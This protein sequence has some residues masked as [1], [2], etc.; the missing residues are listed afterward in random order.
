MNVVL[1]R[2]WDDSGVQH[3]LDVKENQSFPTSFNLADITELKN[4]KGSFNKSIDLPATEANVSYFGQYWNVNEVDTFDTKTKKRAILEYDTVKVLDG[5][6]QLVEVRVEN[7]FAAE[8]NV[9]IFSDEGGLFKATEN[10]LLKDLDLSDFDHEVSL[11]NVVSGFTG[12][13]TPGGETIYYGLQ[14]YGTQITTSIW[15]TTPNRLYQFN[16]KP[17]LK[18]KSLFDLIM[19]EAGYTYES[20]FLNGTYFNSLYL[21][22][23]SGSN[24]I[25]VNVNE[26]LF[27]KV[28]LTSDED[29]TEI[30]LSAN[31]VTFDDETSFDFFDSSD[32]MQANEGYASLFPGY[33]APASALGLQ[34]YQFNVS[35]KVTGG[36]DTVGGADPYVIAELYIRQGGSTFLQEQHQWDLDSVPQGDEV[37]LTHSFTP[38]SNLG[39]YWIQVYHNIQSNPFATPPADEQ[40]RIL[41]DEDSFFECS[42][43]PNLQLVDVPTEVDINF[44][45]SLNV[46]QEMKQ[47]DIL[48]FL[49]AR[50]NCV[51]IKDKVKDN[52]FIIEPYTDYVSGGAEKDWSQKIDLSKTYTVKPLSNDEKKDVLFTTKE[53]DDI[54]NKLVK[55][56]TGRIYGRQRFINDTNQFATGTKKIESPDTVSPLNAISGTQIMIPRLYTDDITPVEGRMRIF[57]KGDEYSSEYSGSGFFLRDQDDTASS[58]IDTYTHFGHYDTPIPEATDTDLNFGQEVPFH[59]YVEQPTDTAYERYWRTYLD[60]LYG[61]EARILTAFFNLTLYD[62]EQFDWSDKIYVLNAWWTVNKIEGFDPMDDKPT[63]VELIRFSAAL[64]GMK[65]LSASD[66]PKT[67]TSATFD[68]IK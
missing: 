60:Q 39:D 12:Y 22:A 63:K 44:Q 66:T 9:R 13:A 4:S 48:R 65:E 6:I 8:F 54:L 47:V 67:T 16:L 1:I 32:R 52:H 41:A 62:I 21:L 59:T 18:L 58:E 23:H 35:L 46:P 19:S 40:F 11:A 36:D 33:V 30:G 55:D 29:L 50:F 38:Q 20:T 15:G 24:E 42:A 57:V 64:S 53:G 56:N 31:G 17:Y 25:I 68:T 10:K 14:D 51:F 5:F 61:E 2:A 43:A 37:T 34:Y 27:C 45:A 3:L 7:G 28:G 49:D 26:Q